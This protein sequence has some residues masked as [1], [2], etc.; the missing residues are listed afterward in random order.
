MSKGLANWRLFLRRRRAARRYFA[1]IPARKI[2]L[3]VFLEIKKDGSD[4]L[5]KR[6]GHKNYCGTVGCLAGWL[7]TMPGVPKDDRS[8]C[9]LKRFFGIACDE[10]ADIGSYYAYFGSRQ[11]IDLSQ[12]AEAMQRLDRMVKYAENKVRALEAKP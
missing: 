2:D 9:G 8:F 7:C 1:G 3:D 10:A 5:I 12:R 11:N 4:A 6:S